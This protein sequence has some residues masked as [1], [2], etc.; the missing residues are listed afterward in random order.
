MTPFYVGQSDDLA[1]RLAEHLLGR[2]TFARHLR[3]RVSTYF[4]VAKVSNPYLRTAT[5]AALIRRL[6]PVGNEVLPSAPLVQ[7]NLP[8][9]HLID[10]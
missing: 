9:F 4:T 2:R 8:S 6:Q 7:I 5:E 1:R 3:H 10:P